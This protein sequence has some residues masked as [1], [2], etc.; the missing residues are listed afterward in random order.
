MVM[1][2]LDEWKV[3]PSASTL[4][5]PFYQHS[6]IITS[7]HHSSLH[8][9]C[10]LQCSLLTVN[11]KQHF[12]SESV[13]LLPLFVAPGYQGIGTRMTIIQLYEKD[14]GAYYTITGNGAVLIALKW[15][16]TLSVLK[17]SGPKNEP[18]LNVGGKF[19][20]SL[21]SSLLEVTPASMSPRL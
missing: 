4:F 18:L 20:S 7:L 16:H 2:E 14:Q 10:L 19:L 21:L 6:P 1:N 13:A 11:C 3:W 5:H 15:F 9:R 12:P 8:S 17:F